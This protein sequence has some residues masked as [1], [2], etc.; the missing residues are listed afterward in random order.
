MLRISKAIRR[1]QTPDGGILL[2]VERGQMFCLNA[3]GSKILN[4]L[5]RGCDEAQIAFLLSVACGE[6]VDTVR[7]DVD[8]FLDVLR[9]H[10]IVR[11]S[12]PAP[13]GEGE[14]THGGTDAT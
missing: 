10:Q 5:D 3:I 1:T 2:D 9:Q 14:A 4:L 8:D 12:S 11:A 6:D 7:A 13:T